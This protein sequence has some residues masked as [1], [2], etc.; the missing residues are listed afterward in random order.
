[1]EE[2]NQV[3]INSG[4]QV[5]AIVGYLV[6]LAGMNFVPSPDKVSSPIMKILSKALH[7]LAVDVTTASKK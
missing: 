7:Y 3:C 6:Y 4:A 1:M 2:V 5:T